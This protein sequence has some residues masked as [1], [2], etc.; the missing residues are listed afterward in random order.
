[1]WLHPRRWLALH[2]DDA[3][4]DPGCID[5]VQ[6]L[7]AGLQ[8]DEDRLRIR[9]VAGRADEHDA[10]R[11][12]IILRLVEDDESLERLRGGLEVRAVRGIH[13]AIRNAPGD[14][15]LSRKLGKIR[16]A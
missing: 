7:P 2:L 13:H 11:D 3:V 6:E 9:A 4:D 16:R 10:R 5:A 8:A 1:G 15:G 12:R 14:D